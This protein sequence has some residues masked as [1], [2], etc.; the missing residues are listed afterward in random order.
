MQDPHSKSL[1]TQTNQSSERLLTMIEVMAENQEPLRLQDIARLCNTNSSTAL[2]FI[3]ALQRKNYVAQDMET[4][5]YYL[6][7]KFCSIGQSISSYINIRTIAQPFLRSVASHFRESCNLAIENDMSIMYIEIANSPNQT[8]LSTQRIGNVAPMHCTGIG[9]LLLTNYTNS[10]IDQYIAI[11]KLPAFTGR[12]IIGKQALLD[13]LDKIS[14]LGYAFDNE[15]CETG[16]RCISAPIRDYTGQI[17]AGISIS[18]PTVR[19]T[20]EHIYKNLPFL[21]DTAEQ[22]SIRMGWQPKEQLN[23][24][25]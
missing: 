16:V 21:L 20:D 25:Y 10:Q 7:F 12:T 22:I 9:K 24:N 13:E 6:T 1:P 11:R 2:R 5:R 15:E 19:M 14:Q 8:L 4:G 18:G 17:T 23:S 3:T